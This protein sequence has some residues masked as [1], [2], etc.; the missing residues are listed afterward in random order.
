MSAQMP[1]EM[2]PGD[3][4]SAQA[5]TNVLRGEQSVETITFP[6][7]GDAELDLLAGCLMVTKDRGMPADD[8]ARAF[9][10]LAR[11]FNALAEKRDR[12]AKIHPLP[13]SSPVTM[14]S[15]DDSAFRAMAA[16]EMAA[17]ESKA[18]ESMI[19]TPDPLFDLPGKPPT[20]E[21][22]DF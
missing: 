9:G 11:R 12:R 2:S 16:R 8:I 13:G 22:G 5:T 20:R 17:R 21:F 19:R 14:G 18:I 4:M 3:N 7:T 1:V 15:A 10:Y 6:V